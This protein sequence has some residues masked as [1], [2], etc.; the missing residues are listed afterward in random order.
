MALLVLTFEALGQVVEG[1]HKKDG[2]G[3]SLGPVIIV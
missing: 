1:K 2:Y 3:S